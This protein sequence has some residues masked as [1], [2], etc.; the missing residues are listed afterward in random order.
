[1]GFASASLIC[2]IDHLKTLQIANV[3]DVCVEAK[4][5]HTSVEHS[6]GEASSAA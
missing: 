1:M 3:I 6:C 5:A 2:V 4:E